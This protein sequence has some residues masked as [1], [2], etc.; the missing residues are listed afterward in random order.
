MPLYNVWIEHAALDLNQTF[1]YRSQY[2]LQ[3]GMRVTVPF[4]NKE[5]VAIVSK[6]ADEIGRAHV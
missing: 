5:L 6:K 3:R 4:N 2:T 1:T